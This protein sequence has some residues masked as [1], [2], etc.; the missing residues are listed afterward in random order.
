MSGVSGLNDWLIEVEKVIRDEFG[1]AIW[2]RLK[3]FK[4]SGKSGAA[5]KILHHDL[6]FMPDRDGWVFVR[7]RISGDFVPDNRYNRMA[8]HASAIFSEK[9]TD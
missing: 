6:V 8:R 3:Y 4:I 9:N 1:A 7:R 5:E 2:V